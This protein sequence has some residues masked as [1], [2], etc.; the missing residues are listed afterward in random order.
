MYDR[1]LPHGALLHVAD[2]LAEHLGGVLAD[3]DRQQQRPRVRR[4]ARDQLD[5]GACVRLEHL[6]VPPAEQHPR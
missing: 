4:A 3:I 6:V 1:V 2:D 5:E